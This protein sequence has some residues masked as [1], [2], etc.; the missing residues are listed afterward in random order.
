M[1]AANRLA[2][3]AIQR[4]EPQ[5]LPALVAKHELHAGRTEPARAVVQEQGLMLGPAPTI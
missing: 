5:R 1:S 2:D 4:R 3:L